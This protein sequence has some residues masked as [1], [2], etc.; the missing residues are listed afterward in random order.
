[1]VMAGAATLASATPPSAPGNKPFLALGDSV[2]FGFIA[3]DGF[4]YV[5]S[6]NFIGY[7]DWAGGDLRL[8]TTNAACPGETSD[9]F[10]ST[11]GADFGCKD[12]RASFPLH[13]SYTSS[14]LDFATNFLMTHKQTRL[15]TISLGSNDVFLLEKSCNFDPHCVQAGLPPVLATL[16]AN[17]DFILRSLHNTGFR[18]VLMV[19][20]YYSLNYDDPIETGI[21]S[22]LNQTLASVASAK[23]AVV[24]D[25][26]TAFKNAAS[27][28]NPVGNTCLAGL[29]NGNPPPP[30]PTLLCDVHPS[31]SGHQLLADTVEAKFKAA[32]PGM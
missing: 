13:V 26:F 30:P 28:T 19:V 25:A 23:G 10:K 17:M 24:A 20:N 22:L 21:V 1:M 31:Q 6:N 14:Q 8:D 5:N 7:P 18:G 12:Y 9:S 11:S 29:L 2:P 16:G 15:V 3:N 27:S 4:A 32:S